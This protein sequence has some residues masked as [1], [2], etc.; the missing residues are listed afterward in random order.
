MRGEQRFRI[1]SIKTYKN[2]GGD[3]DMVCMA[4]QYAIPIVIYIIRNEK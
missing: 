3:A 4:T 2:Y 1:R